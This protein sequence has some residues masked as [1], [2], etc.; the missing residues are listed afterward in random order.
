MNNKNNICSLSALSSEYIFLMFIYFKRE[1]EREQGKGRERE[2]GRH[3]NQ[4]QAPG[5]ELLAQNLRRGSNSQ[6]V[7]S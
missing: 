4:K 3:R 2:R 5:P 7:R 6:A 1:R